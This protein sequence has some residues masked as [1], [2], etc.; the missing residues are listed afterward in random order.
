MALWDEKGSAMKKQPSTK[1]TPRPALK[2]KTPPSDR[3]VVF[4]QAK[5]RTVELVELIADGD[6]NCVSIRFQDKTALSVVI[7]P[8]LTFKAR[9]SDWKTHNERV[10]QRWRTIRN[11]GC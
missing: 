10:L 5:G 3:M 7:D 8:A 4:T 6:Y 9:F 11:G 2:S 1:K